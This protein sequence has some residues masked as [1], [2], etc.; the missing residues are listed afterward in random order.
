MASAPVQPQHRIQYLDVIRGF[1]I[2]GVLLAYVF[3]NLGNAPE[4]TYTS[5][6]IG[7]DKTLTFL[8]DSKC[9]TLL[10]NLFAVGFVLHMNKGGN[11][12]RSLYT[13]RRRL[14]GLMIIG[15]AHAILLRNGDILLPYALLT[16]LVSFFYFASNRTIIIAMAVTFF[17]QVF[18]PEIWKWLQI[19]FPQRP[20]ANGNYWVDNFVWLKFWYA[21]ALFYW[22][23]TLFFLFSGLLLGRI[24]IQKKT[25]L[26]NRQL[27]YLAGAGL[28][29]G[30]A[31][32]W[33]L[34]Y[35]TNKISGLP[36]IGNTQIVRTTIFNLLWLIHRGGLAV[37]YASLFYLLLKRFALNTLA[38]LGRTSL[39][40]YILQAIIVVPG[41]LL[42]NL[43]DHI[44]PT[45]AL[46]M[47]ASIWI[48]QVLFS[49]WWLKHYQFGPLEWLL[50]R[51]TYG[52]MLTAKKIE[53][54][55]ELVAVAETI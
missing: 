14:L 19:P 53:K 1:A 27:I 5:F 10:A 46:I 17:L 8:I 50:R 24:F 47:T 34:S 11:P 25:K 49:T 38:A 26:S 54:E 9:F 41:C 13:Y 30:S 12:G 36:D 43:F 35:Y 42:F 2:T 4:S 28:I 33:I 39:T 37:A 20:V 23:T 6:D 51:F 52:K 21:S 32:Y 31:S 16:L 22:E 3:W 40:N 55:T 18:M 7:L 15:L 29:A 44:T 45:I 48:V